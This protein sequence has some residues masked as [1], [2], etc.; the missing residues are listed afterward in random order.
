MRCD[1]ANLGRGHMTYL[2]MIRQQRNVKIA[3]IFGGWSLDTG[4]DHWLCGISPEGIGTLGMLLNFAVALTVHRLTGDAPGGTGSGDRPAPPPRR[5]RSHGA[6][7]ELKG[8]LN[9]HF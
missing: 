7:S 1:L 6:L 3:Q 2:A 9:G 5:Q 8:Q 4:S